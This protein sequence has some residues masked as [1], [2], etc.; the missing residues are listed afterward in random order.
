MSVSACKQLQGAG[1]EGGEGSGAAGVSS[2]CV[3]MGLEVMC[4]E[5]VL[6]MQ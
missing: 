5:V 6:A 3:E 2:E 1:R 4:L